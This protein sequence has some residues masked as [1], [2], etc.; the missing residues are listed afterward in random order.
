[1]DHECGGGVREGGVRHGHMLSGGKAAL[2]EGLL[3][4]NTEATHARYDL[5]VRKIY[6]V[7]FLSIAVREVS[8]GAL[9]DVYLLD[10][11]GNMLVGSIES[12]RGLMQMLLAYPLGK[13]A[14]SMPRVRVSKLN[15][16]MFTLGFALMI[17]GIFTDVTSL[18]I[19]G[20]CFWA[21]SMQNW[22]STSN[23]IVADSTTP[24]KRT[25]AMADMSNVQVLGSAIGPAVQVVLLFVLHQD[26][27]E[28]PLLHTT[29]GLGCAIWPFVVIGTFM[30]EELPPLE[31]TAAA[32]RGRFLS[33]DLDRPLVGSMTTRWVLAIAFQVGTTFTSM[34]AGMT[35]KL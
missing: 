22:F 11:G 20:M 30:L 24:D 19:A 9:F 25:S 33:A 13:L 26:T 32:G 3:A 1:M 14:D 35:V 6:V 23:A 31:K 34:G 16:I 8:F 15:L 21:P 7:Y 27:W 12:M 17:C 2:A 29:M 28:L 4:E 10:L 5:N 18:I